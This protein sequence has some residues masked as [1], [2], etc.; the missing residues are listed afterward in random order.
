MAKLVLLNC[1]SQVVHPRQEAQE[2]QEDRNRINPLKICHQRSLIRW[3]RSFFLRESCFVFKL[4]SS[5]AIIA[6]L[7]H[8]RAL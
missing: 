8:S 6:G 4:P 7:E 5:I 1:P 2:A 3:V